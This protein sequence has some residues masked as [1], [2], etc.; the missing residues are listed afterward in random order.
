MLAINTNKEKWTFVLAVTSFALIFIHVFEPFDTYSVHKDYLTSFLEATIAVLGATVVLIFSQFFLRRLP[1][2]KEYSWL[3][4]VLLLIIETVLTASLWVGLTVILDERLPEFLEEFTQ[5]VIAFTFLITPP[6]LIAIAFLN[7][8][9]RKQEIRL[10]QE[11]VEKVKVNPD[12]MI[13]IREKS[14][15]EKLSIRLEAL[16][17]MESD[18]NYVNVFFFDDAGKKKKM[19]VRNTL[20]QMEESFSKYNII[21]CHRSYLV[22]VI[23][24]HSFQKSSQKGSRLFIKDLGDS[25]IPVSKLYTSEVEKSLITTNKA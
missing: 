7:I 25:P 15:K 22:N 13:S 8:R 3:D 23:N 10:L 17:Y 6:Y 4:F 19:V 18:D 2:F 21:R 1:W 16:L 9:A 5:N 11:E 24:I 14:G 12:A 20:K